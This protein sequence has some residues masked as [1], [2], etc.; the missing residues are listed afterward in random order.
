MLLKETTPA[1]LNPVPLQELAAHLRLGHGFADD[2]SEDALLE[3]YLRNATAVIETRTNGA[4]IER[5]FT[6]QVPAWDRNGHVHLPVGPVAAI[7]TFQIIAGGN[8]STLDPSD[9]VLESGTRRQRITGPGGGPLPGLPRGGIAEL[10]FTA[11]YGPSWNE[12]PD[13]LRHGVLILAAHYY[14]ARDGEAEADAGLP[15]GLA[16]IL[17]RHSAIRL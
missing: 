1:V 5:D 16:A 7:G 10:S 6:L 13:D 4:L 12:V 17:Q 3:L 15:F 2:G 14:E 8:T 9:W 11:G